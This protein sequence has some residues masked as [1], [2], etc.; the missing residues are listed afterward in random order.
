MPICIVVAAVINSSSIVVVL[1]VVVLTLNLMLYYYSVIVIFSDGICG[2][3]R[4]DKGTCLMMII[5][6]FMIMIT[7]SH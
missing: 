7:A 3:D 6:S 5:M 4:G 2:G 1:I